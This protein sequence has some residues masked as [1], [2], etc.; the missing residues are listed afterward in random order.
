MG[1]YNIYGPCRGEDRETFTNWLYDLDIPDNDD[2]ALVG[3]FNFIRSAQNR[4]KP[5]GDSNDIVLF[6]DIIRSQALVEIPLKGR[7]Y[8]WSN[9]QEDPLLEQLD[10]VFTSSHWT[11]TFPNTQIT[12]LGKPVS[13]HSPYVVN[14]QTAIPRSNIFRFE[15]YWINHPGFL[16][17]VNASWHKHC[18]AKNS[19]ALLCRKMKNLRYDLK[20]WSKEISRLTVFIQNC[21]WALVELD[22][23][24]DKRPLT[25]P[26]T[27]FRRIVKAHLLKLLD[28]R[29]HT[30]SLPP[31]SSV[32]EK[33][34]G[35]ELFPPRKR[36]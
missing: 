17:V 29:C 27:N 16:D 7:S 34:K 1:L 11:Q 36:R 18:Y 22:G 3:D 2:W 8:T 28:Y 26:E 10:W 4:N 13:D 9:M 20:N 30:V 33:A 21:N 24:E 12:A 6:N 25:T 14:I 15:N 31:L 35:G 19:A 32:P 23:L 5:G